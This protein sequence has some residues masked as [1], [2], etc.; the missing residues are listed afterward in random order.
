VANTTAP[1]RRT[2]PTLTA[3]ALVTD[4]FQDASR[5][6]PQGQGQ[7]QGQSP[8]SIQ[9]TQRRK[10]WWHSPRISDRL[11]PESIRNPRFLQ[12]VS[13]DCTALPHSTHTHTSSHEKEG[14][15]TQTARR[16]HSSIHDI[17]RSNAK[18]DTTLA[19]QIRIQTKYIKTVKGKAAGQGCVLHCA[20]VL[21]CA[22]CPYR[23]VQRAAGTERK[24]WVGSVH[25]WCTVLRAI[26]LKEYE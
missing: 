1:A 8:S 14:A 21:C 25:V 19:W 7:G 18:R 15:L 20:A 24:G 23:A 3:F 11:Y 17:N 5:S 6:R 16:A 4:I 2:A 9:M 22:V 10:C 26:Y 13:L 12:V